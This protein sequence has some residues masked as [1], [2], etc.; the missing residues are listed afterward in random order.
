MP[1]IVFEFTVVAAKAEPADFTATVTI[2]RTPNGDF[3]FLHSAG[4]R[5]TVRVPR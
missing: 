5:I 3:E 4:D 2:Q 1:S